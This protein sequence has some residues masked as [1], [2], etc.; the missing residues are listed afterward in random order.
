M[1]LALLLLCLLGFAAPARAE[2]PVVIGIHV[3]VPEESAV[4]KWQPLAQYLGA[5]LDGRVVEIRT[6]GYAELELALQRNELD[7]LFTNPVSHVALDMA[8]AA[9]IATV[10][11]R[12]GEREVS[13]GGGVIIRRA[14]NFRISTLADLRGA[15][16]AV[17]F[18]AEQLEELGGFMAQAYELAQIGIRR[19]ELELVATGESERNVVQA[20]LDKRVDTGFVRTGLLEEMWAEGVLEPEAL[21]VINRQAMPGYPFAVS[22]RLWPEWPMLAMPQSDRRTARRIAWA[23]L[24]LP[25]EHPA[26]IAAGISGFD[27]PANYTGV[28]NAMRALRI[29]P[30]ALEPE[31]SLFALWREHRTLL[32][33]LLLAFS[34]VLGLYL[35][36]RLDHRELR[37]LHRSTEAY[38]N[39]LEQHR[40]HLGELVDQ[41]TAELIAAKESAEEA[42]IAKSAFLA[43]MSHE[44]RTPLNAVIGM[45]Y[46]LT[47]TEMT[48][49]QQRHLRQLQTS[50]QHL[51]S[52][53]DDILD[54]SK[55]EANKLELEYRELDIE[56][57]LEKI[58]NQLKER[59]A[60]KRLEFVI[61]LA[62]DVP[63]LL[64][65]DALRL[66][67]VLI[68]L[69][70]NAVKFTEIGQITLD[71]RQESHYGRRLK[72]RFEVSDTGIGIAAEHLGGLFRNFQQADS[73]TTR[74]YG[75]TG[76]G[77]AI[78]RH[79][80]GLMGGDIGVTSELGVGSCF[81]FTVVLD[82][83]E[84]A[85]A[86]LI[87]PLDLRGKRLLVV[88]D[89][90]DARSVTSTILRGMSFVVSDVGSG[91]E[92]L[93]ELLRARSIGDDFD[94]VFLDQDMPA[95][96]GVATAGA[97]AQLGLDQPPRL[98]LLTQDDSEAL[99]GD[100]SRAGV[101][102]FLQK[103]AMASSL[104]DA[105]IRVLGSRRAHGMLQ[106]AGAVPEPSSPASIR[107]ARV[108]LVDDNEIN[109]EVAA[110]M[111]RHA[112][113]EV[114]LAGNGQEA[115]DA[116]ARSDF[117]VVLMDMQMP[118]MDGLEATRAIR[119]LPQ[120]GDV[121]IIALT[122]NAMVGDRERCTEAG[123][124]DHVAKPI[125]PQLL[126]NTLLRWVRQGVRTRAPDSVVSMPGTLA[127]VP[128][129]DQ[130]AGLEMAM[131][132]VELY[133]SL[134]LKFVAAERDFAERMNHAWASGDH[135]AGERHVHTLKGVAAQI[136]AGEVQVLAEKLETALRSGDSYFPAQLQHELVQRL[137]ELL[138]ALQQRLGLPES[139]PGVARESL[140]AEPE[141]LQ[142][143]LEQLRQ[144]LASD[145]FS[146]EHLLAQHE[147]L[148]RASLAQSWAG[149]AAAIRS[150]RFDEALTLLRD[151][152]VQRDSAAG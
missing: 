64:V 92:A 38:A 30:Y 5:M 96:D 71:V 98:I 95:L 138:R 26:A 123:M 116:V 32:I 93:Q 10:I 83:A 90:D 151:A 41:R 39:E 110:E 126:W 23:L 13:A 78:S 65:G 88:D 54:L 86:E 35:R 148:L 101:E 150:F 55:I 11:R 89:N 122:A 16:V 56:F 22:T 19:E 109:Q 112:G 120:H 76:L 52:L 108:L 94:A 68:N 45:A 124:N 125:D 117:D 133:R 146:A 36:I 34:S 25:P 72:L 9:A 79:L 119:N 111:L 14:D 59:I 81:W 100:A 132:R 143:V 85:G 6:L 40:S 142:S 66:S 3:D 140:P 31:F 42:S 115:V 113:F 77:L 134:L 75:G 4:R 144:R 70:T 58:A 141:L 46:L 8:Q 130:V 104:F 69:A 147:D 121:P 107:G 145:D 127:D 21:E 87:V 37:S 67:Q 105:I 24:A 99:R 57:V 48:A 7:F 128:G 43:N 20:V 137:D 62:P 27:V 114:Q 2:L 73:S 136:G 28:H 18:S 139:G 131:N 33:V 29:G 118:V 74:K 47:R 51:L 152:A 60:A 49:A 149:I 63:R 103:P 129:L 17:S 91:A 102:Y 135:L 12:A 97:I 53:V 84:Q 15:R 44:I 61:R 82:I 80:V 1:R 106:L 50:S